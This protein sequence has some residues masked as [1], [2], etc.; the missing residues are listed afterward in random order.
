LGLEKAKL[1]KGGIAGVVVA[2]VIVLIII[3]AIII[4]VILKRYVGMPG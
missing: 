2:A 4:F 1:S 3:L